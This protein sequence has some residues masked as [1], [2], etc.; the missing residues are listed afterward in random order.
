MLRRAAFRIDAHAWIFSSGCV[1]DACL[2]FT[3]ARVCGNFNRSCEAPMKTPSRKRAPKSLPPA[4][5]DLVAEGG[6]I[7]P[8]DDAT[9]LTVTPAGIAG[10]SAMS[11]GKRGL[12]K[13]DGALS[14]I[15]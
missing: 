1:G 15:G 5:S 12:R 4:V 6:N 3:P 7:L 8:S 10:D 13:P 14:T 2:G 9:K 11:S